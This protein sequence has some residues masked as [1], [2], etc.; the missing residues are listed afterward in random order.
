MGYNYY[1]LLVGSVLVSFLFSFFFIKLI[2]KSDNKK[3]GNDYVDDRKLKKTPRPRLGGVGIFIS[4]FTTIYLFAFMVFLFKGKLFGELLKINPGTLFLYTGAVFF[5][6]VLGL[7]D[8]FFSLK[9]IP[10]LFVEFI[11]AVIFYYIGFKITIVS[12]PFGI[13]FLSLGAFSLPV[14]ILWIVVIINAINLIDGLDGLAGGVIGIISLTM[15]IILILEGEYAL[16]LLLAPLLG[17]TIGFLPYNIYPSK[18]IIGDSGSLFAGAI[19]STIIITT[20]QK[21]SFG[22]SLMVP[23]AILAFP[24]LDISLAFIRRILKG[25]SPFSP[26]ADHIHHRFLQK[27]HHEAKTV[28]ILLFISCIFSTFAILF[29]TAS[30]RLRSF[31]LGLFFLIILGLLQYLKYVRIGNKKS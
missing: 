4:Y 21:A 1:F 31:L 19:L 25:K 22:V 17:G 14:T 24:I 28:K 13:G 30:Q 2:L 8:D 16:T 29:H 26:D 5:I 7:F 10:K 9:P 15:I 6:F 11:I 23:L 12:I 20:P 18:I 27:G 3:K